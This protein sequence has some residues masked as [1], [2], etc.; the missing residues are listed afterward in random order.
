MRNCWKKEIEVRNSVAQKLHGNV[1]G[2]LL[3]MWSKLS[4][5]CLHLTKLQMIDGGFGREV[6][7]KIFLSRIVR[8]WRYLECLMKPILEAYEETGDDDDDEEVPLPD[9][10]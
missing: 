2:F 1:E 10:R 6:E 3:E 5:F 9:A 8:Q 4:E 7:H